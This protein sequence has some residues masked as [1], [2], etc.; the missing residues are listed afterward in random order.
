MGKYEQALTDFNQVIQIE[1]KDAWAVAQRGTTYRKM[2]KYEQA[3]ADI[4]QAIQLFPKYDSVISQRSEIYILTGKLDQAL[5]DINLAIQI[6][7]DSSWRYYLRSQIHKLQNR[8]NDFGRDI[9]KAVSLARSYDGNNSDKAW[10]L[11]NLALYELVLGH[12]EQAS[13]IY[14]QGFSNNAT[15]GMIIDAI[16][17]LDNLMKLFPD[18]LEAKKIR[19]LLRAELDKKQVS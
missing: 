17:D 4:N 11:F 12:T 5:I 16:F 19:D 6:Q 13:H 15:P 9:E 3:L 8:T 18:I 14:R 1:S 7:P 2:G 10:N